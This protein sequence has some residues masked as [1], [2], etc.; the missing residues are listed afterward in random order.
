[1]ADSLAAIFR[2]DPPLPAINFEPYYTGWNYEINTTGGER[3]PADS[4][5][6]ADFVQAQMQTQMYGLVLAGA[7]SGHVHGTAAYD[8]TAT[9]ESPDGGP[10]IWD[11][12]RYSSA[13]YMAPLRNF[14]L[15]EGAAYQD[16][17]LARDDVPRARPPAHRQTASTVRAI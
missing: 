16:L 2:L 5:R 6:D 10:H 3:P 9:G 14:V 7:L 8:L 17:L 4:D 1:M 12:L 15:S 11:A 13:D